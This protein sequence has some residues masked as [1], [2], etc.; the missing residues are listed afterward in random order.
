MPLT[1]P[2]FHPIHSLKSIKKI[3]PL[4][5][6]EKKNK[7]QAKKDKLANPESNKVNL[8][9]TDKGVVAVQEFSLDIKDKEFIVLVGLIVA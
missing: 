8:Q 6:D 4:A 9:I 2:F 3:Y 7:K 5:K 1:L